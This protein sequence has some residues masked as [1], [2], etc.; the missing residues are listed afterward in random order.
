MQ[1]RDGSAQPFGDPDR[2]VRRAVFQQHAEF[3]APQS[4]ERVAFAQLALEQRA[5]LPQQFVSCGVA[6]CI[7]DLLEPVEVEIE[8]GVAPLEVGGALERTA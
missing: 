1:L 5:D 4:R 3:V 8:N 6:A 7:V 2:V